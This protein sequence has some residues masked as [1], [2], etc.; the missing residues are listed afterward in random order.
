MHK[1]CA[2]RR[3]RVYHSPKLRHIIIN[4]FLRVCVCWQRNKGAITSKLTSVQNTHP[5]CIMID[6]FAAGTSPRQSLHEAV[7][8]V[9]AVDPPIVTVVAA[10]V[11]IGPAAASKL[12]RE[13][14]NNVGS[15]G[16][17]A[18]L[19]DAARL[20]VV[21]VVVVDAV[22]ARTPVPPIGTNPPPC[23]TFNEYLD[24]LAASDSRLEHREHVIV[25]DELLRKRFCGRRAPL[26][27]G[28][29]SI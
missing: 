11:A 24:P 10:V 2:M 26:P 9:N 28:A 1:S 14:C 18:A 25:D 20:F 29:G 21:F 5:Q 13:Q 8:G 12:L 27:V 23:D 22:V 15:I 19:P 4:N 16:D 6:N 7:T 17:V 3:R